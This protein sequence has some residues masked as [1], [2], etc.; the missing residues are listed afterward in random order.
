MN[1]ILE[2]TRLKVILHKKTTTEPIDYDAMVSCYCGLI[3]QKM[4][5]AN[6]ATGV[7]PKQIGNHRAPIA[8]LT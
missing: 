2:T 6:V 7:W 4:V 1:L 8:N 5:R 3:L